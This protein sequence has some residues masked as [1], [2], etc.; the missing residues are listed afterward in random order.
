MPKTKSKMFF[1]PWKNWQLTMIKKVK[2]QDFKPENSAMKCPN[3][4]TELW[5]ALVTMA[6]VRNYYFNL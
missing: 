2:A 6:P 5:K 3:P 1:K 4:K